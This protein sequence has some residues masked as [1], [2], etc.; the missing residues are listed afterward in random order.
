MIDGLASANRQMGSD[1]GRSGLEPATNGSNPRPV[2]DRVIA[3]VLA[4]RNTRGTSAVPDSE[5]PLAA[6]KQ[7]GQTASPISES[8]REGES[9]SLMKEVPLK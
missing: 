5:L 7:E 6:S 1:V 3:Q 9:V 4:F 2:N 8:G